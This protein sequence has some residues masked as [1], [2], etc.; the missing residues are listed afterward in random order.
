MFVVEEVN[1]GIRHVHENG[2]AGWVAVGEG[3]VRHVVLPEAIA[4][5]ETVVHVVEWK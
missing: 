3:E 1:I 5:I 4:F 2:G